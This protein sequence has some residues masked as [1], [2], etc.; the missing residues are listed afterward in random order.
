M[1]F[2]LC[3]VALVILGCLGSA[4]LASVAHAQNSRVEADFK[5][6]VGLGLVGAELGAVIPALVGVEAMWAYIA[7]P[8]VGAAGGGLA[9]YF[10]IDKQDKVGLS[11][12]AL[13][14]GMALVLPAL[15]TTLQLTSYDDDDQE[16]P[17]ASPFASKRASPAQQAQRRIQ[18]QMA[19]GPGMVR[20]SEGRLALA[21][22]GFAL[23]PGLQGSRSVVSGMSLALM[24]GQF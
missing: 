10:L 14:A 20:V 1:R 16:Q 19:A 2:R 6:A 24:S 23:V 18:K 8:V 9:G 22:P 15:I 5:G 21:A 4:S 13:T 17:P 11:V 3:A 7:F 12:I